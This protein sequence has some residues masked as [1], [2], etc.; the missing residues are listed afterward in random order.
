MR[1]TSISRYALIYLISVY[2]SQKISQLEEIKILRNED[3]FMV[4]SN[5]I[6]YLKTYAKFANYFVYT[7]K[8]IVISL[9]TKYWGAVSKSKSI[10]SYS[11]TTFF[12]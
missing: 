4:L 9:S 7:A 1:L 11:D 5:Q 3:I 12:L 10:C 6:P 8:Y 2:H